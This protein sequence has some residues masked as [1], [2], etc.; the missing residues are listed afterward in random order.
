[1]M[2]RVTQTDILDILQAFEHSGFA[3]LELVFGSVRVAVNRASAAA[4]GSVA[5]LT[6]TTEVVAPL[7]GVFQA[8]P[9]SG[10]PA[11]V[12]PGTKVQTDTTVGIIRVMQNAT[13]VKAGLRGTVVDVPVQD[14]Q[15]VEFGQTLLRVSTESAAQ[16]SCCPDSN[17]ENVR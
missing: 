11:F 2:Q 5:L 17:R 16:E 15:F 4:V 14:G 13:A 8:G 1:M 10:A 6:P 7:L 3:H 9:E 12:Q